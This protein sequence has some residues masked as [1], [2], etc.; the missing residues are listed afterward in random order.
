[1]AIR[2]TVTHQHP[3]S[4][5]RAGLLSTPHGQIETPVFMPVGTKATV[6][7]MTPEEVAGLGAQIILSNTF[8]LWLRPGDELVRQMG[9]LH[10]FMHWDGPILTDSGGFQVWSL[11]KLRRMEEEG[12]HFQ[13]PLDG[14]KLFL[15]PE[16]AVAIQENL[17]AD[18]IMV[19]DECTPY[20]ATHDY[21]RASAERTARW[22]ERCL[23]A[24][25]REDQALF[26]IVQG[27]VYPDLRAW[28]A[29]ATLEIGFPGYAIGGLSVGET[30]PE[31]EE[32]LDV[33]DEVLPREQ[34]R[35]LMGVGTPEDFF[36]GVERGV[37]MFDCVLPTRT[38]RTGRI[39][40]NEGVLNI[41][42]AR[43]AADP[44]PLSP[45]C[46]CYACRFYSRAYIRH[47]F[48]A[49]EILASRLATTH[50]LFYFLDLMARIREAVRTNTLAQLKAEALAAYGASPAD[51][52]EDG[53]D[54]E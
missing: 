1:M 18:I 20:P 24:K 21:A 43:H 38:A 5:A 54:R 29:R 12:V 47:L 45:T 46:G 39:Y 30:K 34:P 32:S 15:T 33:M 19:L 7:A 2:F 26:G 40:T 37:D 50:N 42:N 36:R 25:R 27:G 11:A 9:G 10:R 35:Y 3:G 13:S 23:R 49:D 41:R 53:A 6:K 22:A 52:R 28:S 4:R 44:G 31:M 14:A 48:M 8:H 17:G 51:G 16:K